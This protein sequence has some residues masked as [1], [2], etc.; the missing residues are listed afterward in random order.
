VEGGWSCRTLGP[1]DT[2][3]LELDLRRKL[4]VE[5]LEKLLGTVDLDAL[6]A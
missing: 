1:E 5:K 3:G 2:A 4:H 6:F